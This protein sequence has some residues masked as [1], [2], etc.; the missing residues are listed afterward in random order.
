M[1]KKI[2]IVRLP[3]LLMMAALLIILQYYV[4]PLYLKETLSPKVFYLLAAAVVL[5]A[6]GGYIIN[7]IFD[8]DIDQINTPEEVWMEDRHIKKLLSIYGVLSI[9]GIL[10][11]FGV[12]F[13]LDEP[14]LSLWAISAFALLWI[15]SW[16]IKKVLFAN[17]LIIAL[18]MISPLLFLLTA[19]PVNWGKSSVFTTI[20]FYL[21]LFAFMLNLIR[22][23]IKDVQDAEGDESAGVN[24][25]VLTYGY[26]TTKRIILVLIVLTVLSGIYL[27]Q[28]ITNIEFY[29]ALAQYFIFIALVASGIV[30]Y[31]NGTESA[32]KVSLHIK[33][34]MAAG[35]LSLL[36]LHGTN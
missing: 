29:Y 11:G 25:L 1:L 19:V 36:L 2:N 30:L 22:E 17:N 3:N 28:R 12:S 15:Y 7:D 5:T 27:I 34:I 21:L 33:L 13:L 8:I 32:G 23:I 9:S 26:E 35:V 4:F 16:K 18:L 6:A 20:I 14:F 31:N 24:S 10:S